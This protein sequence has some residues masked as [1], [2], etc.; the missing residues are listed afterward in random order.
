MCIYELIMNTILYRRLLRNFMKQQKIDLIQANCKMLLYSS[1]M[2]VNVSNA[3]SVRL[4]V[5]SGIN[6]LKAVRFF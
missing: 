2:F 5:L 4:L 6:N 1:S 3:M